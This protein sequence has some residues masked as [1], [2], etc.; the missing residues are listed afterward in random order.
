MENVFDRLE[1]AKADGFRP[2]VIAETSD[3]KE[4]T[5]ISFPYSDGENIKVVAREVPDDVSSWIECR[6]EELTLVTKEIRE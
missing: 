4:V 6:I 5:I 1:A 2:T 3:G